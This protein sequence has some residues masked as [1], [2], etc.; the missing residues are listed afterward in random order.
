MKNLPCRL[1]TYYIVILLLQ[2]TVPLRADN[3][4]GH[5][6]GHISA[7]PQLHQSHISNLQQDGNG[8]L[9]FATWNGLIRFDGH[10]THSFKPIQC[11]EGTIDSNRIY[12]IK[13]ST[14]GDIWC[15]SSDN[16]LFLFSPDTYTFTNISSA[17][18]QLDGRKVKTLTPLKNGYT[19]VTM[20]DGTCARLNDTVPLSD[21]RCY[22]S[23]DNLVDG[24]NSV[25]AISLAENGDEWVLTDRGALNYTSGRIIQ[26]KYRY[27][28]SLYKTTYLIASDGSVIRPA[29]GHRYPTPL[30]AESTVS[31]VR[32]DGH[33][34]VMASDRGI[35]SVD[36]RDGSTLRYTSSPSTYIFKDSRHRLWGFGPQPGVNMIADL[37]SS[38]SSLIP[39]AIGSDKSP[40]KNPQLIF[41][42]AGGDIL[43]RPTGGVLSSYVETSGTLEDVALSTL[44]SGYYDREAI[45]KYIVDHTGNLWVLHAD[46]TDLI[47][48]DRRTFTNT[49]NSTCTETRA[50]ATDS[51]GHLWTSDRSGLLSCGA[52]SLRL[53]SPAYTISE[54]PDGQ[55]WVGTKGDGVYVLTPTSA[56][57]GGY[58]VTHLSRHASSER[59]RIHSDS[60][61]AITF[62]N[63]RIWLGSYG[64]GLAQGKATENGWQFDKVANQ[65]EGMKIRSILPDSKGHLLIATADG[66][67][68]T[69]AP[70]STHPAFFINKFRNE[71]WGLK[72]ND[73]MSLLKCDG[74]YYA[75]VFGSGLSRIDSDSLLTADIRFT[76]FDLPATA[77]AGQISTAISTGNDIW[78]AAGNTLT[79]FSPDNGNMYTVTCDSPSDNITFSE[80][81]PAISAKGDIV[82]GTADGVLTFT[83]APQPA[84]R[85][86][87]PPVVTGIQYQ[88]DRRIL[89]LN[90]PSSLV[91]GP[92]R[93]SFT[94]LLSAM[95]YDESRPTRM[96]YR[97]DGLDA[98]WT[99]PHGRQPTATYNNIPP[100]EYELIIER[101]NRDGGWSESDKRVSVS[102]TP[103]FTET[104][105]FR[106]SIVMLLATL[107]TGLIATIIYFKR[108]RNALQRKY[109]LLMTVNNVSE[110]F[111]RNNT[112][113]KKTSAPTPKEDNAL[114]IEASLR[115]LNDNMDNVDLMVEDFARHLGMS[116]TAYYNRMKEAA[117]VSPVDFIRQMRIK[118]ALKLLEEGN[119]TVAE[120]AYMTGFADPKYFSRC[121]KAEMSMTPTQYIAASK[122]KE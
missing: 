83:P 31:Y 19:W 4:P 56:Q 65:P 121:F 97:M 107:L 62:D 117:G 85:R 16:R 1:Y 2:L 54:S 67:V 95:D 57:A 114:F 23:P 84:D 119:H 43:L 120:V 37:D 13:I 24:A 21:V 55:I 99:Y 58:T 6:S 94:L 52:Y 15:V 68:T 110:R 11:S 59:Q 79:H 69:D 122:A 27:V 42:T 105:W 96:R 111:Y 33:R 112:A 81:T 115:F 104:V 20:R 78:I 38:R 86:M 10:T 36:T 26:G 77:E 74:R 14:T 88:N 75:C 12:N 100:G 40:L 64:E 93:R 80:A 17:I 103:T 9:W 44:P 61:Y 92:D 39:P 116:R 87:L 32:T 5:I 98:G 89:P 109:S 70:V 35:A 49:A 22:L 3:R 113:D 46:G 66:L 48:F 71:P 91:I 101:E 60:I 106:L 8:F 30:P 73:I 90:N 118:R 28:E 45:K 63:G 53:P 34:I 29:D 41:E 18:R 102:V 51:H 25:T 7:I 72:G 82:F 108:M 50:L 76:T 47:N